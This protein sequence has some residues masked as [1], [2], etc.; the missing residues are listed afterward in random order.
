MRGPGE[1]GRAWPGLA[2]GLWASGGEGLREAGLSGRG[3]NVEGGGA[4][5]GGQ[6]KGVGA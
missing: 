6:P 4:A 5:A 3:E 2:R 1:P